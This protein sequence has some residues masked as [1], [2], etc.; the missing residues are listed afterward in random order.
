MVVQVLFRPLQFLQ[1]LPNQLIGFVLRRLTQLGRES[2]RRL[3]FRPPGPINPAESLAAQTPTQIGANSRHPS[4][5]KGL[6]VPYLGC[7]SSDFVL[8]RSHE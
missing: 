8:L 6:L 3:A 4:L 2:A 5:H 1:F 7:E